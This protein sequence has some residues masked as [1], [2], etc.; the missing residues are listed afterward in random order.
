MLSQKDG[1]DVGNAMMALS[2]YVGHVRLS[3]TYWYIEAV[4]ELMMIASDRF[5]AFAAGR[6]EV[7]HG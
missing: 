6:P 3:N 5:D 1:T 4:P 7:C 2:T